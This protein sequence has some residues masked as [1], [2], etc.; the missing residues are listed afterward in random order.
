MASLEILE[1]MSDLEILECM[2][3]KLADRRSAVDTYRSIIHY[4]ECEAKFAEKACEA[5]VA[6]I[7]RLEKGTGDGGSQC[8]QA[9]FCYQHC[10]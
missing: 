1:C 6:D 5:L 4:A 8:Q 9:Q 3:R 10:T 2:R 7:A